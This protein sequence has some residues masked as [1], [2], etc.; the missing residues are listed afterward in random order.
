MSTAELT[1][2]SVACQPSSA[3]GTPAPSFWQRLNGLAVREPSCDL[4]TLAALGSL[5]TIWAGLFYWTWGT[6]GSVTIDSGR[7]MYVPLVLSQGKMLYRDISYQYP[8]LAPYFNAFLFRLFGVHLEVLYW[9]GALSALASTTLV[10]LTGTFFVS[11]LIAWTTGAVLLLEAFQP[12]LFSFPLPYTFASVYGSVAVSLLFWLLVRMSTSR[13]WQWQ[14]AAGTAAALATLFKLEFGAPCYAALAAFIVAGYVRERNWTFLRRW[15]LAVLPGIALCAIVATWMVSIR[16]ATFITHENIDSWPSSYFMR[17]YGK[18]WLAMGGFDLSARAIGVAI[19][20]TI[21]LGIA[22]IALRAFLFRA[23]KHEREFALTIALTGAILLWI[24]VKQPTQ[25]IKL[26]G[27]I[28][29]FREMFDVFAFPPQMALLVAVAALVCFWSYF[30]N[31]AERPNQI[32]PSIFAFSALL[33]FRSLFATTSYG[34]SIYYDGPEIL[35]VLVLAS[36]F[37][38]PLAASRFLRTGATSLLCMTCLTS[39]I[40]NS[41]IFDPYFR[42]YAVLRTTRG[43]IRLRQ[44]LAKNYYAAITFI[45]QRA[46]AG[47]AVMSVPEDT[48][49]YF[50]SGTDCLTRVCQFVP[51]DLAPGEMTNEVIE[52]LE[53]HPPRFLIWSNRQFPEYGTPR[54]GTDFDVPVGDY[55]RAHYRP[56]GL[57]APIDPHRR[58]WNAQIWERV[59]AN[60]QV[61]PR[62]AGSDGNH[63]TDKA[64]STNAEPPLRPN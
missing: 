13:R 38:S 41:T 27:V 43:S 37:I 15:L 54:F 50:F 57:L 59:S 5:V 61:P 44:D 2:L 47:E 30:R 55:L 4:K 26:G 21:A 53:R 34:Y 10:F 28:F 25:W 49:L 24:I 20:E 3:P 8:P 6:W 18:L 39:V 33:S 40:L 16:G 62:Q 64:Y 12:S 9:A 17:T 31:G 32:I 11:R 29:R 51:G 60:D 7:E 56:I 35:C 52:Q 46:A 14:L 48:S 63:S 45:K 58:G 1:N 42:D 22:L 36:M 23:Q 19:A